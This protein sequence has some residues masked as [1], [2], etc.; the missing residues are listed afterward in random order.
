M[1]ADHLDIYGDEATLT[2]A[3]EQYVQ[4]IRKGGKLFVKKGL[5]IRSRKPDGTY[6]VNEKTDYYSDNLRIANGRYMFDYHGV[7]VEIKDLLLGFPGKVNVE[8]ATVAITVALQA[9][10][11]PE[12]IRKSLPGFK[13]VVRRFNICAEGRVLYID[14][15]AHHPKEIEAV[16][17][18][19]REL[20]PNKKLTVSFQPHLYSRT[21]DFN[22]AFAEALNIAD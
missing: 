12:E 6:A 10:V 11:K 9:G 19:V 21:N 4:L 18:S 8:N 15:Y 17:Q 2:E 20:W 1:D 7:G 14:D 5:T 22:E 16:L 3:F 13:G